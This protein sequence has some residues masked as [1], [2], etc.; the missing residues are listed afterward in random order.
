ML[1]WSRGGL[2]PALAAM[3]CSASEYWRLS[4]HNQ[5]T[6]RAVNVSEPT[7]VGQVARRTRWLS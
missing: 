4:I 2:S 7:F 5:L 6:G 1:I 3:A